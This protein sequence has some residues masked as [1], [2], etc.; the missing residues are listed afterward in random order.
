MSLMLAILLPQQE[1]YQPKKA[2]FFEVHG[3]QGTTGHATIWDGIGYSDN[4][5]FDNAKKAHLWILE[6]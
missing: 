3:W 5:Y 4:C 1:N 2:L 6:D